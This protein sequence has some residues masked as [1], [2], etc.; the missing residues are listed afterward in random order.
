MALHT[1]TPIVGV[2]LR[3]KMKAR[4]RRSPRGLHIQKRF[5]TVR[6]LNLDLSLKSTWFHFNHLVNDITHD[7]SPNGGVGGWI[8]LAARVMTAVTARRLAMVREDTGARSEGAAYEKVVN[9]RALRV[10]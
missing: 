4:L 9:A 1:I 3:C 2:V 8:S 7:T 5:K 6:K 10:M